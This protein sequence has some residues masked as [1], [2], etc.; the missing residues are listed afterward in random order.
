M[1]G[2]GSP[3]RDAPPAPVLVRQATLADAEA[4]ARVH[5]Q[6]WRETYRG[7]VPAEHLAG[8][9][10]DRR[11]ELWRREL[12]DPRQ[13]PGLVVAEAGGA[14]VGFA[15]AGP[16]REPARGFAGELYAI[17]LLRNQQGRGC[18]RRLFLAAA[19]ALAAQGIASFMLW[20]LRDNP[21][22]GFYEHMGGAPFAEQRIV[23]GDR[24]LVEIAYGWPAPP[25]G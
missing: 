4:I 18:G 19:A 5:I 12:G 17:Y 6:A 3:P 20:V 13:A 9:S 8:L 21:N 11:A 16:A 25:G 15:A 14:I 1:N 24:D 2:R 22:R 10:V 7:L 23:I